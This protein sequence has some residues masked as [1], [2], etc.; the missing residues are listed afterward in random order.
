MSG[1]DNNNHPFDGYGNLPGWPSP[2]PQRGCCERVCDNVTTT[3]K[4]CICGTVAIV[5][6]IVFAVGL[7]SWINCNGG[8]EECDKVT[9]VAMTIG[10]AVV[11]LFSGGTIA[12]PW[13]NR[14]C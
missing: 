3:A 4:H 1:V 7:A 10:G 9:D 13:C 14:N 2:P 6:G 5:S 8:E 12:L 11:F